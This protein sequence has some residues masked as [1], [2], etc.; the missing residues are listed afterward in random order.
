MLEKTQKWPDPDQFIFNTINFGPK[1]SK[2]TVPYGYDWRKIQGLQLE[3]SSELMEAARKHLS[4]Y[5]K[6]SSKSR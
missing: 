5:Q 1:E 6:F 2:M 3:A 4:T